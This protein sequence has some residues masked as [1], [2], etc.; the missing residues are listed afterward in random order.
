IAE[1]FFAQ[2]WR[3]FAEPATPQAARSFAFHPAG[4]RLPRA[5][6]L[7]APPFPP[8]FFFFSSLLGRLPSFAPRRLSGYSALMS[9]APSLCGGLIW[10]PATIYTHAFEF[11]PSL[12]LTCPSRLRTG[13]FGFA[14]GGSMIAM[15]RSMG[16]S[17][18]Q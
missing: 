2:E 5:R 9:F 18:E 13:Q 15:P 7:A 17:V 10:C 8:F 11:C 3:C 4:V 12:P 14:G 1:T 6:V 16:G